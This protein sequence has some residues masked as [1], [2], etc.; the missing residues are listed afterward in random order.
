MI[1][2]HSQVT[3]EILLFVI[4][5]GGKGP[6]NAYIAVSHG[7]HAFLTLSGLRASG[8]MCNFYSSS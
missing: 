3:E 4:L 7:S 1:G 5:H 2:K 6:R 8:P